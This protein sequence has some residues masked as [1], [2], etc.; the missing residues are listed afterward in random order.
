MPIINYCPICGKDISFRDTWCKDCC[1]DIV[2]LKSKHD[3]QYYTNKSREL[4]GD[5]LHRLYVLWDEEVSKNPLA[6]IEKHNKMLEARKQN[7]GAG[8]PIPLANVP[9][10]PTCGSTNVDKLS[11]AGSTI[12]AAV[13]GALSGTGTAG[14]LTY[15]ALNNKQ[16]HCNNCGYKW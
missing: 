16:F 12:S 15:S 8:G 9:K 7:A 11:Q 13:F 5:S 10:C 1:E 3:G 6:N 2:P 14:A 4:Y